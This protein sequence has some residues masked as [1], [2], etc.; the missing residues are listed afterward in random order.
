MKHDELLAD[1]VELVQ[2]LDEKTSEFIKP[3]HRKAGFQEDKYEELLEVLEECQTALEIEPY[4]PMAATAIFIDLAT[5]PERL[6]SWY[7]EP[8]R[9]R[10]FDA[11]A[12]LQQRICDIVNRLPFP[13][14]SIYDE[15]VPESRGTPS[16]PHN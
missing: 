4:I 1:D 8:V 6:G 9:E 2:R 10:I 3:L 12:I 13:G 16:V 14:R 7:D 15:T 11:A 5:W